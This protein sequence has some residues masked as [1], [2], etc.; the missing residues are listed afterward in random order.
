MMLEAS[1]SHEPVQN[2]HLPVSCNNTSETQLLPPQSDSQAMHA[3]WGPSEL[4]TLIAM[5]KHCVT[6]LT[7][8]VLLN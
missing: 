3:T 4:T 7:S 2:K 8:E 6:Y 5:S 1:V